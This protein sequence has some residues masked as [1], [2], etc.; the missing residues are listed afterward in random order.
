[1]AAGNWE[2]QKLRVESMFDIEGDG[3]LPI[4]EKDNVSVGA[5]MCWTVRAGD[6]GMW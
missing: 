4:W 6:A 1:M 5:I 3:E 2:G